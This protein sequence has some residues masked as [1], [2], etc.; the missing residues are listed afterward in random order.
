MPADRSTPRTLE[1][2][3][4]QR[5]PRV[6]RAALGRPL[7]T[8]RTILPDQRQYFPEQHLPLT[9]QQLTPSEPQPIQPG[10]ALAP[11][12]GEP[13]LP[14]QQQPL[15]EGQ[16]SPPDQVS[17]PTPTEAPLNPRLQSSLSNPL[18]DRGFAHLY[19]HS[20]LTV[21]QLRAR[22]RARLLYRDLLRNIPT[23]GSI[24]AGP[25]EVG[26]WA[27]EYLLPLV[28]ELAEQSDW[29]RARVVSVLFERELAGVKWAL[30]MREWGWEGRSEWMEWEPRQVPPVDLEA[31]WLWGGYGFGSQG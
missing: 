6:R 7:H 12:A 23:T 16:P 25:E 26:R 20:P 3:V 31:F 14:T 11:P 22:H 13:V 8:S 1:L 2:P 5:A 27:D 28:V 18:P 19:G 30:E 21:D 17:Q 9:E 15:P 10:Q 4:R 24:V 29:T